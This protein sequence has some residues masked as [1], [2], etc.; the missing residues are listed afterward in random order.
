[1]QQQ[2]FITTTTTKA[3]NFLPQGAHWDAHQNRG[4][5]GGGW[6]WR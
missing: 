1:M 4:K 3:A 5:V 6:R 2:R